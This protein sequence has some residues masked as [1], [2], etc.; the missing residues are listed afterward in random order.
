MSNNNTPC[1][2]HFLNTLVYG[3]AAYKRIKKLDNELS[4]GGLTPLEELDILF[5][6]LSD[7]VHI[8]STAVNSFDAFASCANQRPKA[9]PQRKKRSLNVPLHRVGLNAAKRKTTP[10]VLR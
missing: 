5:E 9:L 6:G 4:R 3:Y 2:G 1:F 8:T 10:A 7:T